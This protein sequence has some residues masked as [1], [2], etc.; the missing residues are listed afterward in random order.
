M[1]GRPAEWSAG[2]HTVDALQILIQVFFNLNTRLPQNLVSGISV[3]NNCL[4]LY[5]EKLNVDTNAQMSAFVEAVLSSICL[6]SRVLYSVL[7]HF[8]FHLYISP[9][10][11]LIVTLHRI[12]SVSHWLKAFLSKLV[13]HTRMP[14]KLK[15][16]S[17]AFCINIGVVRVKEKERVIE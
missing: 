6:R 9:S 16:S 13:S 4:I 8:W 15:R 7:P 14:L 17:L 5:Q 12:L 11:F 3:T 2:L 1:G 10:K